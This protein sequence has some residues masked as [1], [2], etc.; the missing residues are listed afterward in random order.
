MKSERASSPPQTSN[1]TLPQPKHAPKCQPTVRPSANIRPSST[2]RPPYRT[3][4]QKVTLLSISEPLIA[5]SF[6]TWPFLYIFLRYGSVF[7]KATPRMAKSQSDRP[8]P[9]RPLKKTF[10]NVDSK[11]ANLILNEIVDRYVMLPLYMIFPEK[12][13]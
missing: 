12:A 9:A 13:I 7:V 8:A 6:Y 3:P 10:K 11:L 2:T 1:H 5:F 4:D